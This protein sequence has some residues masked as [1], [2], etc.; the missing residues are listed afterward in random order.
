M[1]FILKKKTLLKSYL[2]LC[3]VYAKGRKYGVK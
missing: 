2:L 3:N 1:A